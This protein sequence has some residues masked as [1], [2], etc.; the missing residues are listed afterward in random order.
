MVVEAK[1]KPGGVAARRLLRV[2]SQRRPRGL[3]GRTSLFVGRRAE[4]QLLEATY[5]RAVGLGEP[6][7]VTIMG[8]PGVGKSSLVEQLWRSLSGRAPE[9]VR[10][11]ARCLPYGQITYWPL[12]EV[13][14]E[15]LGILESDPPERVRELLGD[16][17]GLGPALGLDVS[18]DL[19]PL[20]ARERLHEA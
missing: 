13:V 14:K 16:H 3:T 17:E 19:H 12:G 9:P 6:H 1:G 8:E 20:A 4:L 15:E 2:V 5:E 18:E 10:R 7:L 11:T